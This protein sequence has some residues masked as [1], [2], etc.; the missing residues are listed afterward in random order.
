M[1]VYAA[2]GDT[3]G[4]PGP[5]FLLAFA[6]GAVILT[7]WG[8]FHRARVFR[9]AAKVQLSQLGPQ[10]VAYLNGGDRLAV[11]SSLGALRG[12]GVVGV[13]PDNTL[14]PTAPMPAGVTPLDQAIYNAAGKRLRARHLV[15]DPWVRGALDQ[16]RDQ[17][18]RAG[19]VPTADDRR[20]AR[21]GGSLLL[22]LLLAGVARIVAGLGNE[23]PVGGLAW[24]CVAVFIAAFLLR[25]GGPRRTAAAGRALAE[26]RRLNT[27]L[28]PA[29]RPAVATYGAAGAA[30]GVALF[31]V[32]S[33]WA[34]DPAFAAEA[35]IERQASFGGLSGSSS[36]CGGGGG[37]GG[38]DGGGGS[39]GGGGCGGGGG[40]CGG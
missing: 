17:L 15:Q 31:G 11:Y 9:G 5:V 37:A 29:S 26:L 1:I 25:R 4:I 7:A 13:A 2:A 22:L 33:L 24:I 14:A 19:L 40:G 8:L 16:L 6:A 12:A 30:M 39:G 35:E 32:G 38:G 23:K 34:M 21:F 28:A 27:H 20:A 3:W 36:A 10:Q 18:E